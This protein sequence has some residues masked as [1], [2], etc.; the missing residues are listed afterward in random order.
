MSCNPMLLTFVFAVK[1]ILLFIY[2]SVNDIFLYGSLPDDP[3]FLRNE[4]IRSEIHNLNGPCHSDLAYDLLK[5]SVVAIGGPF[6]K[7]GSVRCHGR[8]PKIIWVTMRNISYGGFPK[9]LNQIFWNHKD[10]IPVAVDDHYQ[11]RFMEVAYAN[12]SILRVYNAINPQLG[13][14]RADLWRYAALYMM[15]G[16]Y[17]DFDSSFRRHLQHAILENDSFVFATER[18]DFPMC[19]NRLLASTKEF[20]F[21]ESAFVEDP[22][23]YFF[24]GNKDLVQW[25]MISEPKHSLLN[26]TL[27]NIVS[28]ARGI[29]YGL[30]VLLNKE[31]HWDV[32]NGVVCMTGPAMLTVTLREMVTKLKHLGRARRDELSSSGPSQNESSLVTGDDGDDNA[33]YD[34]DDEIAAALHVRYV[35]SDWSILDASFK[36]LSAKPDPRHYEKVLKNKSVPLLVH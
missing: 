14:A 36:A 26:E 13:A 34:N 1:A 9:H 27:H 10:W 33:N 5:E 25:L 21:L 31:T 32:K 22:E 11:R 16:V 4:V 20:S 17:I 23:R 30:P 3:S 2:E 29:R 18:N 15:G 24:F 28:L 12:T 6:A 7:L 19:Y 8:I 35:G